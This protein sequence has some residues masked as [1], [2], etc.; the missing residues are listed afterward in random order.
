MIGIFKF[1]R[2]LKFISKAWTE[3]FSY[4]FCVNLKKIISF[5]HWGG[6]IFV[7]KNHVLKT[8]L[9]LS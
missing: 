1:K 8:T 6:K 2:N 7:K 9:Y 5:Y 4:K 3:T